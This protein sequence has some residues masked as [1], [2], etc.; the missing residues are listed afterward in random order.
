MKTLI[1]FCLGLSCSTLVL[2]QTTPTLRMQKQLEAALPEVLTKVHMEWVAID[3]D[4]LM[5]LVVT[6]TASDGFLHLLS[7]RNKITSL[8]W[9]RTQI[10]SLLDGYLQ[11]A[12]M[13]RDNRI[14]LLIS[15][16]GQS[17]T[18][19]LFLFRSLG[20][21]SFSQTKLLDHV[22]LFRVDDFNNDCRS[23]LLTYD[24]VDN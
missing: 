21:F 17:N 15:G 10:T 22:G 20:D 3:D 2:G 6:G 16:H 12:D 19:G 13:D 8:E 5:D 7:F 24:S 1:L 14:D 9:Q 23:D 11:L 4:T 18:A